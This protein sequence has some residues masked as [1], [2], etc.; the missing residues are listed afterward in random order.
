VSPEQLFASLTAPTKKDPVIEAIYADIKAN[1]TKEPEPM[2]LFSSITNKLIGN[3]VQK[4]SVGKTPAQVAAFD[5]AF[6]AARAQGFDQALAKADK[7]ATVVGS[8]ALGAASIAAPGI[9]S[10]V[11]GLAP[12]VSGPLA[13]T[14]KEVAG[15]AGPLAA[16]RTIETG[17]VPAWLWPVA[18]VVGLLLFGKKLFK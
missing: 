13:N 7:T 2:G 4:T 12:N 9:T 17:S 1:A 11:K 14:N 5:T 3:V 8:V 10:L 18:I 16:T 15:T 6:T